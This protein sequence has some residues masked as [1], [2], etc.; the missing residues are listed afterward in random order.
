M[1]RRGGCESA[2]EGGWRPGSP[3][4]PC[5]LLMR[6]CAH[7][8]GKLRSPGDRPR[9]LRA[10]LGQAPVPRAPV[11]S[12]HQRAAASSP[13]RPSSPPPPPP[14][15]GGPGCTPQTPRFSER[16]SGLR[17]QAFV[18]AQG[19]EGTEGTEP[20]LLRDRSCCV[21][22]HTRAGNQTRCVAETRAWGAR[23]SG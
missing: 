23:V 10:P 6:A 18:G 22:K 8:S 3:S 19:T 15:C 13:G 20:P 14:A 12:L 17:A 5:S 1:H 9:D 21:Q 7:P 11:S 4:S 2:L 16:S